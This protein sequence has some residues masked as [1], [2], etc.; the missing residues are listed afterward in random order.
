MHT[1]DRRSA[2]TD[3]NVYLIIFGDKGDSGE[4]S[5]KNSETHRDKFERGQTDVFTFK[6]LSLGE[7]LSLLHY[8]IR[9][10]LLFVEY[11]L[12]VVYKSIE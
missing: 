5:L 10:L 4:L 7:W 1:G 11:N 9:M 8:F 6:M 12:I 2:G 3:A